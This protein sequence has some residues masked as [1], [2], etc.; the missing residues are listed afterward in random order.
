MFEEVPAGK[1]APVYAWMEV[2]TPSKGAVMCEY[3]NRALS[4]S[5]AALA[6]VSACS[7]A[8]SE[9]FAAETPESAC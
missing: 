6:A 4:F 9:S 7:E 5:S 1:S 8:A 2:T 3:A